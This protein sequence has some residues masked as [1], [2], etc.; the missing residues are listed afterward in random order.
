[1]AWYRKHNYSSYNL[2]FIFL[3]HTMKLSITASLTEEEILIIAKSKWWDFVIWKPNEEWI[4]ET[5]DNP[6]TPQDF[7]IAVYQSMIVADATRVFTEYRTQELKDQITQT[8]E[9]V[10]I[11]VTESITSSIE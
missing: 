2:I 4:M 3:K 10:K 8:E 5:I 1:M 7:I 9:A 6:Q 11:Q